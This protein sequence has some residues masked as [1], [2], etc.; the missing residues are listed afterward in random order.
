[1]VDDSII[2]SFLSSL[3]AV[4]EIRIINTDK[5]RR[6]R[7]YLGITVDDQEDMIRNLTVEEYDKG[8]VEDHDPN[9]KTKLWIFKH[10]YAGTMIYIKITEIEIIKNDKLVRALSCHIDNM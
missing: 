10:N 6:T 1:M 4:D 5:N 8:P 3:K 2:R 9:R 7:Y